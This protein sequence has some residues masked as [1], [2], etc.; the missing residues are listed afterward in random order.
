MVLISSLSHAI[1]QVVDQVA[2]L[3]TIHA[4]PLAMVSGREGS[5][6]G[7]TD[8]ARGSGVD[9]WLRSWVAPAVLLAIAI[10]VF[11]AGVF[12]GRGPY[13]VI[14]QRVTQHAALE[15]HPADAARTREI[16][17]TL[18]RL[19]GQNDALLLRLTRIEARLSALD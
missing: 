6:E 15:T 1:G 14:D 4:L 18:E 9:L 11:Q 10:V 12:V 2:S 16:E 7:G 13:A 8:P 19:L 5:R 3:L 17:R